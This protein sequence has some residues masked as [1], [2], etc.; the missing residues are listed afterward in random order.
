MKTFTNWKRK[1]QIVAHGFTPLVP[2]AGRKFPQY[3]EGYLENFA[4]FQDVDVFIARFIAKP[5]LIFC[6]TADFPEPSLGNI[7]LLHG[8]PIRVPPGCSI[9]RLAAIYTKYTTKIRQ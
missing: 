8:S 3:S 1:G 4:V 5:L 9:M 7:G 2:V 6:G